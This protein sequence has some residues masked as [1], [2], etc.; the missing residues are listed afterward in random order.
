MPYPGVNVSQYVANL[1]AINPSQSSPESLD[2][3]FQ[4]D[5]LAL[6]ATAQFFDFEMGQPSKEEV[7]VVK[8]P[9]QQFNKLETTSL[10]F[11]DD[12]NGELQTCCYKTYP[13]TKERENRCR[14]YIVLILVMLP[15]L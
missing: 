2:D 12:L 14:L 13:Q 1:N 9:K 7:E 6:F 4:D 3:T 15:R 10:G 5:D 8:S 11:L